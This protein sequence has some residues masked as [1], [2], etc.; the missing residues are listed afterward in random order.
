MFLSFSQNG[1]CCRG[2]RSSIPRDEHGIWYNE[3][4]GTGAFY[5]VLVQFPTTPHRR[6]S[7]KEEFRNGVKNIGVNMVQVQVQVL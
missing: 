1:V 4:E 5:E 3:V 6:L 7:V 2:S